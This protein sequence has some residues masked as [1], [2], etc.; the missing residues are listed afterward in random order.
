MLHSQKVLHDCKGV[1]L[2]VGTVFGELVV[3]AVVGTVVG[4][5]TVVGACMYFKGQ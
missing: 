4:T 3:G 2:A 1:R 5:V